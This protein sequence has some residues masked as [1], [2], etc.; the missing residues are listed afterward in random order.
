VRL[1]ELAIRLGLEDGRAERA[2]DRGCPRS[3]GAASGAGSSGSA[4][5][6]PEA[7]AAAAAA[8]GGGPAP[9]R[10]RFEP[11]A[12]DPAGAEI[13]LV[14]ED[15]REARPGALF[16]AFK[17]ARSDG[18]DFIPQAAERGAAAVLCAPPDPGGRIARLLVRED[19]LSRPSDAPVR[20][21]A[22]EAARLVCGE[23]DLGLL[24]IGI[25]GTNGK[26]TVSCL[27]GDLLRAAGRRPGLIG[28]VSYRFPDGSE[29]E[30]PNTTPEG[31]VLWRT[32]RD[33]ADSG[34]DGLVME[35][36]SHA[37]AM[38]RLGSL[39]FDVALFTNLSR[40]HLDFHLDMEDYFLAKARLFL[41]RGG[42][43]AGG[44]A[45]GAAGFCVVNADD[46]W[47][48]RLLAAP[49][50]PSLSFGFARG[51]VRGELLESGRSGLV[52]KA[53]CPEGGELT[54]RSRLL[55]RFNAENLLAAAALGLALR[56]PPAAVSSALSESEGA[57]GRLSR[58]GT[59]PDFLALI[60]YAH[61]PGALEAALEAARGLA[62]RRLIVIFGCG[63][64]RDRGKR[65]LMGKAAAKADVA[66]LT[67]DNPRAE[68]PLAIIA[69]T[70]PGLAEGGMR[71]AAPAEA[72]GPQGAPEAQVPAAREGASGVYHV[73][74]DR[75]KAIALGARLMGKG[76]ILLVA[77]KGHEDY[78][79]VGRVKR[80]F[81]DAEETL[82]ALRAEG[83]SA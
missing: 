13:T 77:G 15:S 24:K 34:A 43:L 64:D 51:A 32:V 25:T 61:A 66:I 74:P 55:G 58:T 42:T 57:P 3:G 47:G 53:A 71:Q 45:A 2:P 1:S 73:E 38:G 50:L 23:P 60:D 31:P 22:S 6:V 7:S 81:D 78:Q 12:A 33:M 35:V 56:L 59:D 79:I 40:D 67:S 63:G 10:G 18:R 14:T 44:P 41:G 48:E 5:R 16:C 72:P 28:T 52:L 37:L 46:P 21:A 20:A 27:A 68:D 54:I 49:G 82:K 69:E 29:R 4:A 8:A 83:K 80:H 26:S 75:A 17:G 65:P 70:E 30:A 11:G 36:S 39:A 76:D 19:P 62:P 9:P